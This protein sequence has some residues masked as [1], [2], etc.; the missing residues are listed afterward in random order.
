MTSRLPGFYRLPPAERR[1]RIAEVVGGD[2]SP[3]A[4]RAVD[5]GG[6]SLEAADGMLLFGISTAFVFAVILRVER[7]VA[8]TPTP[9]A[10]ARVTL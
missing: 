2:F 10:N 8:G 7:P 1:K 3:F 9:E 5:P 4:F 6:L